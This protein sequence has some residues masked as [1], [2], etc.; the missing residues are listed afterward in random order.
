MRVYNTTWHK[1]LVATSEFFYLERALL[2]K[3]LRSPSSQF[4]SQIFPVLSEWFIIWYFSEVIHQ[5]SI[6]EHDLSQ[7]IP[8]PTKIH[9]LVI[10][11]FAP[12]NIWAGFNKMHCNVFTQNITF[13]CNIKSCWRFVLRFRVV[14]IIINLKFAS[15]L[16]KKNAYEVLY[17]F[18]SFKLR[19]YNR[20]RT[21]VFISWIR[22]KNQIWEGDGQ[23][24]STE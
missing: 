16:I 14:V 24:L 13:D 21:H 1:V 4:S 6:M 5:V 23:C 19:R 22:I 11:H 17:F 18:V 2:S 7:V 8:W 9:G 3:H 12:K 20:I 15:S 10:L